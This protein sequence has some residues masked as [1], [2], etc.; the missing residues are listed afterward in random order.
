[1]SQPKHQAESEQTYNEGVFVDLWAQ[2]R[3][4]L[5][6]YLVSRLRSPDDA[7][8]L[9]S[10]VSEK[11][12]SMLKRQGKPDN[13]RAWL[14]ACARHAL[15]DHYRTSRSIVDLSDDIADAAPERDVIDEL[16][17]CLQPFVR[18]L[19]SKYREVIQRSAINGEL[20][21][22]IARDLG[23]SPSAIKSRVSRARDKLIRQ[24]EQCC[25]IRRDHRG[26]VYDV[27]HKSACQTCTPT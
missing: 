6:A 27:L 15:I 2:H 17:P 16:L 4:S 25:D 7:E 24:F 26:L 20:Y 11:F 21:A 23:V 5:L 13:V 18:R 10:V 19:P 3:D 9:L 14:Y 1:M 22:D 8:D 12:L